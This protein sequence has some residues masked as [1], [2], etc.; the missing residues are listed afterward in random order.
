MILGCWA[1]V[2]AFAT[3]Y[4]WGKS[5]DGVT[6]N[7]ERAGIPCVDHETFIVELLEVAGEAV[8]IDEVCHR[9]VILGGF[10]VAR[11]GEFCYGGGLNGDG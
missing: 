6:V 5:L 4:A 7:G 10:R 2:K 3:D 9:A 1:G 8:A 11:E